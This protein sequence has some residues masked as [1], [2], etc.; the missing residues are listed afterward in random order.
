MELCFHNRWGTICDDDWTVNSAQVVC[1]QLGYPT[2]GAIGALTTRDAFFGQGDGPV[3]LKKLNCLGNESHLL[4]CSSELLNELG[5]HNCAH[6]RDAGVIC[7]GK[8]MAKINLNFSGLLR[9][10]DLNLRKNLGIR[11][12]TTA[13]KLD[14]CMTVYIKGYV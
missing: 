6:I 8:G 2:D 7:P 13:I 1:R 14:E 5:Q 12:S 4:Q 3:F 10:F 11:P 9:A